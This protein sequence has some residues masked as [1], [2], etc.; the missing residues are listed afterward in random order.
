VGENERRARTAIAHLETGAIRRLL[1][2]ED[3]V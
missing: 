1:E 3:H 2:L